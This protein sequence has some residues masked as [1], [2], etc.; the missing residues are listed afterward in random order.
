[1]SLWNQKFVNNTANNSENNDAYTD[2][3]VS[4]QNLK[5]RISDL[6]Q[7]YSWSPEYFPNLQ[8]RTGLTGVNTLPTQVSQPLYTNSKVKQEPT[9][10][11]FL[12]MPG[13]VAIPNTINNENKVASHLNTSALSSQPSAT[14]DL[15]NKLQVKR[16]TSGNYRKNIP[17]HS[18]GNYVP[19]RRPAFVLKLWNMVN[20]KKNQEYIRWADDGQSFIIQSKENFD[21]LVL[22]RYFKHSNY[23]SFVRQ[24]NLYGWHKVQDVNSGSMQSGEEIRQF[25]SPYFI[26]GREDLL[27][28]IVRNKGAKGH[29]DKEN[30]NHSDLNKIL[31]ELD[32]IKSN[33]MEIASDLHRIKNDN[34]M[35][36]RECYESRERHKAHTDMFERILRLLASAFSSSQGTGGKFVSDSSATNN[37][38]SS[39]LG[40]TGGSSVP[41]SISVNTDTSGPTSAKTRLLLGNGTVGTQISEVPSGGADSLSPYNNSNK[42]RISAVDE[43]PGA[44]LSELSTPADAD[45]PASVEAIAGNNSVNSALFNPV[46]TTGFSIDPLQ[47]TVGPES[48]NELF[49]PDPTIDFPTDQPSLPTADSNSESY[50]VTSPLVQPSVLDVTGPSTLSNSTIPVNPISVVTPDLVPSSQQSPNNT[51]DPNSESIAANDNNLED[52]MRSIDFQGDSLQRIQDRLSKYFPQDHPAGDNDSLTNTDSISAVPSVEAKPT[53][54]K[55]EPGFDVDEFLLNTN[56]E[57]LVESDDQEPVQKKAKK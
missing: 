37:L 32:I 11:D 3:A 55:Q 26:R 35:L 16:I 57:D 14:I 38:I 42:S 45:T 4:N 53:H 13:A 25:K 51:I 41:N 8:Q 2:Q 33:Q 31:D 47:A 39:I 5:R 52:L 22:P 46:A 29:S 18:S 56:S 28:K 17:S 43:H 40:A 34:Q 50:E 27:D 36:W 15:A 49:F 23:S 30:A 12:N 10:Y 7:D 24:L 54:I 21:Q 9:T 44:H 6:V 19:S 48:L 1:M 20:D